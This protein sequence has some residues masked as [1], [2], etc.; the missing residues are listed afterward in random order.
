[1]AVFFLRLYIRYIMDFICNICP[2]PG[3]YGDSGKK[4]C[5]LFAVRHCA[6][7]CPG[8][9][10]ARYSRCKFNIIAHECHL[11][12]LGFWAQQKPGKDTALP[13]GALC[14]GFRNVFPC[15]HHPA[16]GVYCLLHKY[17]AS[18]LKNSDFFSD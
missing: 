16:L 8:L 9:F 17:K 1:M 2:S 14:R 5:Y 4:P 13:A 7:F 6:G 18:N 10:L 11:Y 15:I 12:K 3:E